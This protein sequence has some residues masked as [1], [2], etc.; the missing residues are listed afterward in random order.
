VKALLAAVSSAEPSYSMDAYHIVEVIKA[1]Q[2]DP[3]TDPEDIFLV[4]WAYLPL[5]DRDHSVSPKLLENRLASDPAFFCEVIRF[6]YRSNKEDKSDKEPSE[7]DKS[8]AIN[9]WRLLH[10][11]RTP[12][13][14]QPDGVFSQE[15]FTQWLKQTKETCVE[16]GHLEV[17]LLH[18]GQVLI[19][20][21][22]DSQGLWIDQN[23]ADA[24][25][26]KDAE[27]MRNGFRLEVF[28]SRGAYTVDPTGKP[29]R[30]LAEQY[31]QK[32]D[33]VENAGYQRFAVTLR[34]LAES[35]DRD[36]D[37]IINESTMEGED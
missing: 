27:E 10:K 20:C 24:L 26:G 19:Y 6:I 7:Q 28:N 32:A 8:I 2:D 37:Q 11:W 18:I 14:M 9:A 12:P 16:S 36:A 35:Y 3:D 29:E 17:A 1:L 4:E 33:E 23:A 15:Q 31:R 34:S 5:L 25:N 22:P 21:P 30:E 13:G